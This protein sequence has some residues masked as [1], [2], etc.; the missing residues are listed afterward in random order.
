MFSFVKYVIIL[1]HK[2]F[3]LLEIKIIL[4]THTSV[5][6]PDYFYIGIFPQSY[7]KYHFQSREE[8]TLLAIL[9]NDFII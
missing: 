7:S 8:F 2:L 1:Y 4:F 6:Y 5:Y 3:Y 9:Y